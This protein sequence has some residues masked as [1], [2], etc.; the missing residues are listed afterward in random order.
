ML[1]WKEGYYGLEFHCKVGEETI[2][3]P[4]WNYLNQ[5]DDGVDLSVGDIKRRNTGQGS[6]T[7]H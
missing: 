1:I 4:H 7:H 2:M 6:T 5:F 3:G